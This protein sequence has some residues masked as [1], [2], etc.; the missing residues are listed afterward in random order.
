MHRQIL[1]M[2]APNN[3]KTAGKGAVSNVDWGCKGWWNAATNT[4]EFRIIEVSSR[5]QFPASVRTEDN[6][7]MGGPRNFVAEWVKYNK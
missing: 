5:Y 6:S 7:G 2:Y 3:F 1:F 4:G